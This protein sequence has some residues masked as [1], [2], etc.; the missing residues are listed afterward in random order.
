MR[1]VVPQAGMYMA[2]L[3]Q[4]VIVEWKNHS[5]GRN[6]RMYRLTVE[7]R[8]EF[9]SITDMQLIRRIE[10]TRKNLKRRNSKKHPSL[11]QTIRNVRIDYDASI[12]AIEAE[13]C[14]NPNDA[15]RNFLLAE[16]EKIYAG[17]IFISVNDTNNRL[18]SNFTRLPS[19]F[20]EFLSLDGQPVVELD[21][22]NSQ[23][24]FAAAL[25]DPKPEVSAVMTRY[26]G[27]SYTMYIKSMQLSEHEDA[28]LYAS[29]V[30]SGGFY[31]YMGSL[32][33][34][35][36]IYFQNPRDLKEKLFVVFF[37][38]PYAYRYN[39]AAQ[40]FRDAFPNVHQLFYKIKKEQ[41]N[42]LAILLQRVESFVML[43]RVVPRIEK[44]YP[45]LPMLTKHDSVQPFKQRMYYPSGAHTSFAIGKIMLDEIERV[46]GLRPSGKARRYPHISEK[47]HCSITDYQ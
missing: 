18:D 40:V 19:Y 41:H 45:G 32:F 42:H 9:R 27:D 37:D 30:C 35:N 3:K 28:K 2:F 20:S 17:E 24:F 23:P 22:T 10:D 44:E 12:A 36:G 5:E 39:D 4:E 14:Q 25:F 33:R 7:G 11:N 26:L 21:I 13:H 38:K 47:Q 43:N 34:D 15:R 29:L 8:T 16:V 31:E 46:T 1:A 6:S